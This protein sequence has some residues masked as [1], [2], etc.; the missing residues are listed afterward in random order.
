MIFSGKDTEFINKG[1]NHFRRGA[2]ASAANG[3]RLVKIEDHTGGV[4]KKL[5]NSC[6]EFLVEK[7]AGN[8]W[9]GQQFERRED[10]MIICN[11]TNTT[12]TQSTSN[13]MLLKVKL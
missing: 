2:L 8:F 10:Q 7:S 9:F 6:K 5:I 11:T 3:A 13:C 1:V 4:C 12:L